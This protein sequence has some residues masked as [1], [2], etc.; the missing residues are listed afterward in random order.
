MSVPTD[1][2]HT[3]IPEILAGIAAA[4][5]AAVG[6]LGQFHLRRDRHG[7]VIGDFYEC[8]LSSVFQPVFGADGLSVIGHDAR[9]RCDGGGENTLSPWGIFSMIASD[10]ALVRLDRLCRSVHILNY[11]GHAPADH[12][13]FLRVEP[14]LLKSVTHDHGRIFGEVLEHCRIATSK[15]VIVIPQ[16]ATADADLLAR[17][18][19]NYRSRGYRLAVACTSHH[20]I[21][22]L[23]S[24]RPDFLRVD[25]RQVS[26]EQQLK[27]FIDNVHGWGGRALVTH[28]ES[29]GDR[30]AALRAGTDA[31]QGYLLGRPDIESV[32]QHDLTP[33]PLL[34]RGG[35]SH[36]DNGLAG[37]PSA[38]V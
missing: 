31:M 28:I 14:R 17:V 9:V 37:L 8:R 19:A 29:A 23:E 12:A 3:R 15:V 24:L 20:D 33:V 10:A 11:F 27:Q 30:M 4:D 13:L 1:E 32:R 34:I 21:A 7:R 22:P 18:I 2:L 35:I 38:R 5:T 6:E 16:E 36:G 26:S 25:V